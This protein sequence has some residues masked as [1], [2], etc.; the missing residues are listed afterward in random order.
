MYII[1]GSDITV[2]SKTVKELQSKLMEL[3]SE[4]LKTNF[5]LFNL[6]KDLSVKNVNKRLKRR[7]KTILDLQNQDNEMKMKIKIKSKKMKVD[8]IK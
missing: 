1:G 3:R 8:L 6:K 5:R 7:K 2:Q 4:R